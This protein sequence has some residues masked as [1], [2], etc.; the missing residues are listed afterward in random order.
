MVLRLDMTEANL[1][2]NNEQ[3]FKDS[4]G[5]YSFGNYSFR[6]S[7]TPLPQASTLGVLSKGFPNKPITH[8]GFVCWEKSPFGGFRGLSH[9]QSLLPI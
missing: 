4:I 6:V 5:T 3:I 7:F 2:S 9:S 8:I 1:T